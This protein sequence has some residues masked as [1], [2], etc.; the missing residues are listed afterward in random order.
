M[1]IVDVVHKD[2]RMRVDLGILAVNA[3]EDASEKLGGGHVLSLN[4]A[5]CEE[6][7]AVCDATARDEDL[8]WQLICGVG[9]S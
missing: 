6:S 8:V 1:N 5:A 2:F 4:M 3:A 9:W 7:P